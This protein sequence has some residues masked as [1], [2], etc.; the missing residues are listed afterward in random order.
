MEDLSRVT[1]TMLR[2]ALARDAE[3]EPSPAVDA[4]V[5]ALLRDA[6]VASRALLRP[7]LAAGLAVAALAALTSALAALFAEAGAAE[8]GPLVALLVVAIYLALSSAAALP[9]LL[10]ARRRR[11]VAGGGVVR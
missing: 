4:A 6:V 1:E 10:G 2:R 9:L 8:A 5:R 7:E 11:A 3:A